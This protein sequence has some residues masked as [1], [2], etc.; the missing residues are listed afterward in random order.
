MCKCV[1]EEPR[2]RRKLA[3]AEMLSELKYRLT[4][5]IRGGELVEQT[6]YKRGSS[7]LSS[8]S[9]TN[10]GRMVAITGC[11]LRVLS[12]KLVQEVRDLREA[13]A[14][15][16]SKQP[17]RSLKRTYVSSK[18]VTRA[19]IPR[20]AA[21]VAPEI[22]EK[23]TCSSDKDEMQVMELKVTND[24]FSLTHLGSNSR[25]WLSIM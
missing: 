1:S 4:A 3:T 9:S 14:P 6:R 24:N 17:S 19:V 8:S 15:R 13:A 25:P 20:R 23:S 21:M 11:G 12:S 16:K 22:P 7:L 10:S 18:R 2:R 5:R